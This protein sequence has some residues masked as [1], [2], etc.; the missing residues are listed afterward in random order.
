VASSR[1]LEE[2][3]KGS[4]PSISE[5]AWQRSGSHRSFER[6]ELGGEDSTEI[7]KR[8]KPGFDLDRSFVTDLDH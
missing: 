5:D 1:R 2:S 4:E 7:L 8:R 3:P 6:W